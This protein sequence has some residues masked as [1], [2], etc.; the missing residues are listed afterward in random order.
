MHRDG[1]C[2][3]TEMQSYPSATEQ[4]KTNISRTWCYDSLLHGRLVH[5]IYVL[6]KNLSTLCLLA[7]IFLTWCN[8]K[9]RGV[10]QETSPTSGLQC[11]TARGQGPPKPHRTLTIDSHSSQRD[12]KRCWSVCAGL[13]WLPE[14][15]Q[16]ISN[17]AVF[18][19]FCGI[20][21]DEMLISKYL[22]PIY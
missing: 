10:N 16:C 22:V 11:G 1:T 19:C 9:E 12:N 21:Q 7:F 20:Q 13:K 8:F 15:L 4:M 17:R 5:L 6:K 2:P 14:W 18:E 3:S